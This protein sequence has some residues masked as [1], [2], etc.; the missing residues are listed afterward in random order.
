MQS[1]SV[2]TNRARGPGATGFDLRTG[3]PVGPGGLPTDVNQ[4]LQ[5]QQQLLPPD[6]KDRLEF[7]DFVLQSTGRDLPVFGA[8]LFRGTPSTF[9]PI[10]N[11][12][13]TPDYIIGPGDEI[14][15]RAWGQID[16][17]YSALV[18]RNGSISVPKVGVIN[19]SGIRYRD[20]TGLLKTAFGRVFRSFE[21]TA[22]LGQLRSIQIFVVGQAK[23]P[24][25]YT[26]SS[27]SSLVTALFAVG[28]PSAKGSMRGIQLKRG[29]AVVT[30]LDLY[31][32]LVSGDKSKDAALLPGDV[33][34]IPPVGE[35]VAVTGSV[36][37][38]AIYELKRAAPL[39][40]LLR[41]AGGLAA[42]AQ[43][44]KVTVERID[45]RNVRK[46][47]EFSLD[48]TGL[49]RTLRDGDLVTVF[50]LT[51]RFD[52]AVTLR[53]NV[54]QPGRFP[55]RNG[56]RVKDLIPNR[57]SLISREYWI[58]QSQIVGMERNVSRILQEQESLGIQLGVADLIERPLRDDQDVTVGEAIRRRQIERDA[59]R[60]VG[61]DANRLVERDA[62][63]PAE[64]DANARPATDP[65]N[66][67]RSAR[68]RRPLEAG[69]DRTRILNQITPSLKE[70]NWEYAVIER[71]S[72]ADLTTA[73]VPFNLGKAVLE[74]DAQHN[75]PL[76]PGDV[77]TI[78]SREDLGVSQAK[79]TK[80]IRLEG[81]LIASGVYQVQPR[82]TLR[83]LIIR[84]G[85][86]A[87]NAYLFGAEF[88]RESTRLQQQK[89]L[90]EAL[91]R[92]EQDVERASALRAQNVV[93]AEDAGT[94]SQQTA[95]QQG[96]IARLR[97]IRP[98]GRIVI[99]VPEHAQAKDLPDL[100]LED[101]DRFFV[102]SIPSMV[103]VFGS[104]YSESS[105]IYKPE[106][107][108][109]DYLAQAGGPT[110]FA[111]QSS[112]YVLRADGSVISKRQS[113]G[114]F[115]VGS[116]DGLR[117]MPGD[118]VVVPEELDRTTTTRMLRDISQIF[119]QFGLGAA[120][121]RVLRN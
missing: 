14:L 54:A 26:V 33:I 93:S 48:Q 25:T 63:R 81:E 46:V 2:I 42:T 55:W 97:Q 79:Q 12:P 58:A 105:F 5:L 64:R 111:D 19:V 83:Q 101:G 102:P 24:G 78:F 100:P 29:N 20:L 31:E 82:E 51:P 28:G 75:L 90:T 109:G 41:W 87:P 72:P 10:D 112:I 56:M 40:D 36:N 85:G 30:D 67:A 17:D 98:T 117:L 49:A 96:L 13:V 53:G 80:F 119:Y 118:S 89:N 108:V 120:A 57:E 39:S 77:V 115:L 88:T 38:P 66:Q 107:R 6:P 7:Q 50:A 94:I 71:L 1:P 61:R 45:Q 95:S 9:A 59:N 62:N 84:V 121:I 65:Q 76:Q 4:F 15:I 92:L 99:E 32:L 91:N 104:V 18:D 34:H 16:V 8:T 106:K 103:N 116:I 52:N 74:A 11:V 37:T 21:L 113:S 114:F 47:E 23:R 22:T 86:L 68:D 70:V 60:L 73:L 110:R 43:G 3:R 27:L 69:M 35:L 44:Q